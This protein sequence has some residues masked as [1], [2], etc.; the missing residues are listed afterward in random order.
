MDDTE[1]LI[2]LEEFDT[3]SVAVLSCNHRYHYNCLT[4]WI[5]KSNKTYKI[6][7]ICNSDVE[8]VNIID[9]N[10]NNSN[11]ERQYEE[12]DNLNNKEKRKYNCCNIL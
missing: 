3:S 8:I 11:I 9:N 10:S 7:S 4:K 2:C 5:K 6:C 12:T 1:C